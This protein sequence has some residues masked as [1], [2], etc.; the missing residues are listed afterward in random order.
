MR[1]GLESGLLIDEDTPP[2]IL[3]NPERL[4]GA[5]IKM[6]ATMHIK[7]NF[8]TDTELVISLPYQ[9]VTSSTTSDSAR[10]CTLRVFHLSRPGIAWKALIEPAFRG[11]Y[12]LKSETSLDL[13]ADLLNQ[14]PV[15]ELRPQINI[16]IAY[17]R[18]LVKQLES[19]QQR[20]DALRRYK[21]NKHP[22][23]RMAKLYRSGK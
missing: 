18:F 19:F 5:L 4:R 17:H 13:F 11:H 10:P 8:G 3:T 16:L 7:V 15:S 9:P 12:E 2:I 23:H 1:Q 22:M 6:D 14:E 20:C 21:N